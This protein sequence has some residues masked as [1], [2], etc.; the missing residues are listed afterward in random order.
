[1]TRGDLAC[2]RLKP[3]ALRGK[4]GRPSESAPGS[5]QFGTLW[6]RMHWLNV[7]MPTSSCC[8]SPG[9]N[10]SSAPGGSK[11]W[12]ALSAAWNWVLLTPSCCRLNLGTSPPLV[13]SGKLRMPWERMQ[14]ENPIADGELAD[15]E[16]VVPPALDPP[17]GPADEGLLPHPAASRTRA[18]VAMVAALATWR[19]DRCALRRRA[20]T[21]GRTEIQFMA[22]VLG[23]GT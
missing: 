16:L 10:M 21:V 22:L 23:P 1:V 18:A 8:T 15:R 13:G 14:W 6:E 17:R 3:C 2:C 20:W 7:S 11:S 5:G 12:Q 4:A 19:R 9:A